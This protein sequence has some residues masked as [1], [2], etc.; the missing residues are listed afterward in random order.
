MAVDLLQPRT[1]RAVL[2]GGVAG[3]A[4]TVAAAVGRP[5]PVRAGVPIPVLLGEPND[6]TALTTI[7]NTAMDGPAFRGIATGTATGTQGISQ[8]GRGLYGGSETGNGL[9]AD[10]ASSSAAAGVGQAYAG[11]CGLH[12]YSGGVELP[13]PTSKTGVYGEANQDATAMGVHGKSTAGRGVFG[14]ATSGYGV[15][16]LAGS[17]TALY[18]AT[19]APAIGTALRT[20][21][22]VRFDNSVGI[23]TIRAGA[24]SKMVSPGLDLTTSSAVVA[25]LQGSAGGTT[26]VHRVVVD[27]A[28]NTFRIYLTAKANSKVK[29]AWHAFN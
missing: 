2:M 12:G 7:H 20:V 28:A 19:S 8:S 13:N 25:T 24:K 23:A 18:G 11:G 1:R 16:G 27:A 9:F 14:Q 17:G 10:T 5:L 3:V 26:T 4:A 15:R 29:V 21:G 22:K 6:S